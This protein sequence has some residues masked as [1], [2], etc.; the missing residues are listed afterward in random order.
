MTAAQLGM[1]PDVPTTREAGFPEVNITTYS[2]I[3]APRGTPK[4][5]MDT[6]DRF[7]RKL[8]QNAEYQKELAVLANQ[9]F[10]LSSDDTQKRVRQQAEQYKAA[11]AKVENL[12]KQ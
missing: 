7:A 5:V 8:S 4:E 3:S 11:L 12:P 9:A 6:L 1:Q 2:A 10:Y